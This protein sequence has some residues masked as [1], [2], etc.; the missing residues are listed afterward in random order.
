[1]TRDA[2][3]SARTSRQTIPEAGY[4]FGW[5]ITGDTLW[6]SG[7]SIGFRNVIVRWP[8]QH[9]T[10]IMLSNRNEFQPYPLALAIGQLFLNH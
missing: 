1:M 2:W 5:R 7:E 4:G 9:L 10:V 6:H 3:P 8:K